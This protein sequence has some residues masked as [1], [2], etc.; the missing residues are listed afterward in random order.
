MELCLCANSQEFI[1][2]FIENERDELIAYYSEDDAFP[3]AI[4]FNMYLDEIRKMNHEF[5]VDKL[6]LKNPMKESGVWGRE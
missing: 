2:F 5:E 3:P 4:Q 1:E 6:K